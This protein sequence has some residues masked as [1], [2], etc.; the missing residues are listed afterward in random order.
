LLEEENK[1]FLNHQK[2]IKNEE[3]IWRLKFRS[4]WLKEGDRNTSFFHKQLKAKEIRNNVNEIKKLYT[5]KD[6][7]THE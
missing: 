3:S 6:E 4:L 1:A 7:A 5:D 2:A